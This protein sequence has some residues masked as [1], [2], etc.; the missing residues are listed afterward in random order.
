MEYEKEDVDVDEK[1]TEVEDK[2]GETNRNS[3]ELLEIICTKT[4]PLSLSLFIHLFLKG[5]GNIISGYI[6]FPDISILYYIY[7]AS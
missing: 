5:Y 3:N 7:I 2:T 6:S 1:D 4:F